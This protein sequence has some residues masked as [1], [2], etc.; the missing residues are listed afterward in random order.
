MKLI[1]KRY[2]K[3]DYLDDAEYYLG[4]SYAIQNQDKKAEKQFSDFL[5]KYPDSPILGDVYVS[6]GN[7]YFRQEKA[8]LANQ[9]F[10]QELTV[11]GPAATR[12]AAMTN[13]TRIYQN[14]GQWDA[15]LQVA[16]EYVKQFPHAVDVMD[17][18]ILIGICL[19]NLNRY[20]EAI[21]FLKKIRY[22][23]DSDEEPEIQFYI[24]QAYFNAGQYENAITE[25]VKI[26]LLSKRTKLQWEASALYYSGQAYEKLGRKPDAVR[27]YQEIIDRPGIL[28][29]LKREA[30]KRIAQ[31]AKNN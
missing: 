18:N 5:K 12:Q 31:L 17:K 1:K 6:L 2:K 14:L 26:P 25:F 7:L 13:L 4:L 11:S 9:S 10:R 15:V 29:E 27:M 16:R 8:D 3:T 30:R 23:A 28:V 21:D 24:G 20:N 19:T 22:I